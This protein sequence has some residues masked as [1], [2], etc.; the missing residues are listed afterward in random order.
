MRLMKRRWSNPSPFFLISLPLVER[1]DFSEAKSGCPLPTRGWGANSPA[2]LPP[3][4]PVL[5][6]GAGLPFPNGGRPSGRMAEHDCSAKAGPAPEPAFFLLGSL[7]QDSRLGSP[8]PQQRGY[9]PLAPL[10]R[11]QGAAE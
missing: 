4:L 11:G 10:E 6:S 5:I 3:Y 9:W 8:N 7:R 2:D 1:D